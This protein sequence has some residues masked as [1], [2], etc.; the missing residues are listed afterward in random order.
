MTEPLVYS[1]ILN[2]DL[3]VA[4]VD[5]DI[6]TCE[7]LSLAFRLEG[8]QTTFARDIAG[9]Q[10]LV[11]RRP[12]DVIVCSS[13]VP[14][15]PAAALEIARA[16]SVESAV[17][18]IADQLGIT[19]AIQLMRAGVSFVFTRPLNI[20]LILT[21]VRTELRKEIQLG[22]RKPSTAK[23]YRKPGGLR[24]LTGREREILDLVVDGHTN[25]EIGLALGIS[26][27][28]A[29]VHRLNAMQKLGAR[30]TAEMIRIATS[31]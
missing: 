12:P 31:R 8:F 1:P 15:G 7:T 18:V 20:E 2:R 14:Q 3:L 21:E 11:D 25:K 9:L 23:K 19:E 30:N 22:S 26:P 29:E 10:S 28:T 13:A 5:P 16:P 6:A 27:R 24:S 4:I 17:F